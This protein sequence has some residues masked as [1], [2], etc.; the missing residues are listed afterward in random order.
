VWDISEHKRKEQEL[1]N[2]TKLESLAVLAGG[3]AHDFNNILTVLLGNLSI[4]KTYG[5]DSEKIL[6]KLNDIED[7]ALQTKDLANQLLTFS[8]GGS[9][10]KSKANIA[11]ILEKSVLL[12]KSGANVECELNLSRNLYP[13]EV[14]EGQMRQVFNNITINAVQAMSDGGTIRVKAE[15]ATLGSAQCREIGLPEGKYVKIT[16]ADEGVGIPEGHR[17]RIFD[18]F[19]T[20]KENGSGLGLTTVK[21]IIKKHDGVISVTSK[22]GIGT[23]MVFYLPAAKESLEIEIMEA[24]KKGKVLVMDDEENIRKVAT[25]MLTILG[26]EVDT[27]TEGGVA[28]ALYTRAKEMEMPY[29]AVILDLTVPG[30]MGGK[31]TVHK[32]L[33]IDLTV[34]VIVS[35]GYFNDPV[36]AHYRDYGFVEKLVKPYQV[37]DMER[38]LQKVLR[39]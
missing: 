33:Q 3:I 39:D 28:I 12:A 2:T 4:A 13:V 17:A 10:I 23:T 24:E 25:E 9:P 20:T 36:L 16:F 34:K 1:I 37:A 21:S 15:N 19:F 11:R 32:L 5:N 22:P 14:D 29:D 30:G 7:A 26:Y 35:S 6:L 38:V 8:K 27:A 31:E 18:P